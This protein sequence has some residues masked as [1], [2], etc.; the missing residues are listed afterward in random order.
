MQRKNLFADLAAGLVTSTVSLPFCFSFRALIFAGP[1]QL[2]LGQ[3]VAVALICSGVIGL[4][5]TLKSD[6]Q[7]SVSGPEGNTAALIAAMM[8]ALAPLL[9]AQ[10]GNGAL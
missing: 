6:F 3:G 8:A 9:A 2:F 7:V 5:I 4:A 10:P 1:L